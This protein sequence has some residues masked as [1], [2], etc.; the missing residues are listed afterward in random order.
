MFYRDKHLMIPVQIEAPNPRYAGM[1]LEQ[2]GGAN[3]E[4]KACLQYFVQSFGVND[5]T[6]RDLL[7]D[8]STEEIGHLEVVGTIVSQFMA[9]TRMGGVNGTM[10]HRMQHEADTLR[11]AG[12]TEALILGGGGPLLADSSGTPFTG[13]YVNST[14]EL[15]TDLSSDV[16]AE[17]GAK[18]V[19]EMLYREIPDRGARE[20]FDFLIQREEAHAALFQEALELSRQTG[21]RRHYHDTPLSRSYPALSMPSTGNDARFAASRGVEPLRG[22]LGPDE[23]RVN[24]ARM[25]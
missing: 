19:Y 21:V 15:A 14:G 25:R 23:V 11:N 16:A 10:E 5:P 24:L 6:V 22:P 3:S 13:A 17:L 7:M 18:R 2:F 8:I 12:S 1:V 4:L 9:S 20:A